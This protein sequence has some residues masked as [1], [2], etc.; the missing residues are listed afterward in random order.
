MVFSINSI[1]DPTD[2]TAIYYGEAYIG[3]LTSEN[4]WKIKR[5]IKVSDEWK[6]QWAEGDTLN[7]NVWDDRLS[8]NYS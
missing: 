5:L 4:K 7:N 8:L 1:V 6:L 2:G 3:A